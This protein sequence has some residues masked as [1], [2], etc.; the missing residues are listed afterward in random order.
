MCAYSIYVMGNRSCSLT[1]FS[2]PRGGP[3]ALR[4][5]T[6]PARAVAGSTRSA[7]TRVKRRL[8]ARRHARPHTHTPAGRSTPLQP[9]PRGSLTCP[10]RTWP[11]PHTY[12]P[13]SRLRGRW[14]PPRP[15]LRPAP[16]GTGGQRR[17]APPSPA[18][19]GSA[20]PGSAGGG[21]RAVPAGG[22]AGGCC[23]TLGV[24]VRGRR[25]AAPLRQR[26]EPPARAPA[27]AGFLRRSCLP[28]LAAGVQSSAVGPLRAPGS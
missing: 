19:P 12:L 2:E 17:R 3:A 18:E 6:P 7:V 26:Q 28:G 5:A 14:C 20:E 25:A 16:A 10:P 8:P 1:L 11:A 24:V 9:P 4:N 22:R 13:L 15:A 21:G 23:G 27:P